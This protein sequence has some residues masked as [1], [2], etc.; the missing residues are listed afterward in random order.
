VNFSDAI[1]NGRCI[2]RKRWGDEII[3]VYL[4]ICS[5]SKLKMVIEHLNRKTEEHLYKLDI[6]DILAED[7]E[8]IN[9][10]TEG[11]L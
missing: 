4:R 8:I 9:K 11:W 7:W 10:E 5:D 6:S 1:I 2:K 3:D